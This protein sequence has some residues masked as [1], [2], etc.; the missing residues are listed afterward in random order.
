MA[1]GKSI[2]ETAV[3]LQIPMRVAE[4]ALLFSTN[5]EQYKDSHKEI[6]TR[7]IFADEYGR[8]EK[9]NDSNVFG[10]IYSSDYD[11]EFKSEH[12]DA[13]IHDRSEIYTLFDNDMY[14][15]EIQD[16]PG[17][18]VDFPGADSKRTYAVIYIPNISYSKRSSGSYYD[19]IMDSRKDYTLG[20][21]YRR[22]GRIA[23]SY[24]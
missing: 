14:S 7:N 2:S 13:I 22:N 18:L 5:I 10:R 21:W 17:S 12:P 16:V 24:M 9:E 20:E 19:L 6:Y 15:D 1:C 23:S 4:D 3:R 8:V 11:K